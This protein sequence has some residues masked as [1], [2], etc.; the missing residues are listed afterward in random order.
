MAGNNLLAQTLGFVKRCHKY[1]ANRSEKTWELYALIVSI[2]IGVAIFIEIGI[3]TEFLW[4]LESVNIT[5]NISLQTVLISC[6]QGIFVGGVSL[7]CYESGDSY[8]KVMSNYFGNKESEYAFSLLGLT[9]LGLIV[10]VAIPIAVEQV[11]DFPVLQ[12]LGFVLIA[13]PLLTHAKISNW[14]ILKEWPLILSGA[15]LLFV[16]ML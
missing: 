7:F 4:G 5:T 10:G 1:L 15:V 3:V 2:V 12:L 9:A 11:L 8:V 16:P 6:I 14:D 13:G